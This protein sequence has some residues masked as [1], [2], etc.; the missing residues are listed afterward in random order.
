MDNTSLLPEDDF[1]K[2]K[3]EDVAIPSSNQGSETATAPVTPPVPDAM[4]EKY[5][6]GDQMLRRTEVE[7]KSF[8]LKNPDG[9]ET[10]E[11]PPIW[12]EMESTPDP[13][14]RSY[15]GPSQFKNIPS[16]DDVQTLRKNQSDPQ[17]IQEFNAV[18]GENASAS[19]LN[20]APKKDIDTLLKNKDDPAA[21]SEFDAVYG[22]GMANWYAQLYDPKS[23][24]DERTEAATNIQYALRNGMSFTQNMQTTSFG[25]FMQSIPAGGKQGVREVGQS[26]IDGILWSFGPGLSEETKQSL[27]DFRNNSDLGS[28]DT[29]ILKHPVISGII[30]G[31]SQFGTGQVIANAVTPGAGAAGWANWIRTIG[32]SALADAFAFDPNDPLVGD[33]LKTLGKSAGLPDDVVNKIYSVDDLDSELEKRL[34]R[35]GEG[36]V[37]GV[38]LE[39]L[40][41]GLVKG[42][43]A[44]GL[45]KAGDKAA[46]EATANEAADLLD[47]ASKGDP[48]TVPDSEFRT[49][50]PEVSAAERMAATAKAEGKEFDP[51][52]DLPDEHFYTPDKRTEMGLS[53][54]EETPVNQIIDDAIEHP[55][56]REAKAASEGVAPPSPAT[57]KNPLH[58]LLDKIADITEEVVGKRDGVQADTIQKV[59]PHVDEFIQ[60][61]RQMNPEDITKLLSDSYPNMK[62][63]VRKLSAISPEA[64]TKIAE[65]IRKLNIA[66]ETAKGAE[67]DDIISRQLPEQ[68]AIQEKLDAFDKPL[69]T[70]ASDAL[71]A[72]KTA[73]GAVNAA[74]NRM[75]IADMRRQGMTNEQ[76]ALHI[77]AALD[78]G[79]VE[80]PKLRKLLSDR[81]AASAKGDT[82]A[83]TKLD[84]DIAK[85]TGKVIKELENETGSVLSRVLKAAVE[86][87]LNA[88]LGG[89]KTILIN[90]PVGM[91]IGLTVRHAS[92]FV[93]V[94][95]R[96][97]LSD[98]M[99][100]AAAKN[101]AV[102][103]AY[104]GYLNAIKET[105]S[106]AASN[107]WHERSS[108]QGTEIYLQG[109]NR[110]ISAKALGIDNKL[111]GYLADKSGRVIRYATLLT[112][113]ADQAFGRLNAHWEIGAEQWWKFGQ[114]VADRTNQ[115]KRILEDTKLPA[116]RRATLEKEL[117]DLTGKDPKV[118]IGNKPMSFH[119]YLTDRLEKAFD[120]NGVL[121]DD[122]IIKQN[123]A[124]TFKNS[125]WGDRFFNHDATKLIVQP[126]HRTP[127]NEYK[128]AFEMIP[129]FGSISKQFKQDISGM[130]GARAQAIASGK[131][132]I[133]G[134][135]FMGFGLYATT[136]NMTGAGPL[137]PNE[138]KSLM[139]NGWPGPN[140][141]R[142]GDTWYDYSNWGAIGKVMM[143]SANLVEG[144]SRMGNRIMQDPKFV[145]HVYSTAE[146]VQ[147][148]AMTTAAIPLNIAQSALQSTYMQ[149]FKQLVDLMEIFKAENGMDALSKFGTNQTT[150][151]IPALVK[152]LN[153]YLDPRAVR[154]LSIADSLNSAFFNKDAV[155]KQ[156]DS[157]GQVIVSET[158]M[159]GFIGFFDGIQTKDM[160]NDN[161]V[162]QSL[163]N[164]TKLTGQSFTLDTKYNDGT[165]QVE[166]AKVNSAVGKGKVSDRVAEIYSTMK[167]G[168]LTVSEALYKALRNRSNNNV[169]GSERVKGPLVDEL[170]SIMAVYRDSAIQTAVQNELKAYRNMKPSDLRK[171]VDDS[172]AAKKFSL[173]PAHQQT[174]PNIL[175]AT[176]YNQ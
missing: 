113:F 60:I 149:G 116:N 130:N 157:L 150:G 8:I 126:F 63:A 133:G 41:R 4:V 125:T 12:W 84:K 163:Q 5:S 66:S 15:K 35:A 51:L 14:D 131:R 70:M 7:N 27:L 162:R 161:Y 75:R 166:L 100:L 65:E 156:Y 142:I 141:I 16:E 55:A 152:D 28:Q 32:T 109:N 11:K 23:G 19:Y 90:N 107:V 138:R 167:I 106:E 85:Q 160:T 56:V 101:T 48:L 155:A 39:G 46:G 173:D 26:V 47:E 17:A 172:N 136:G 50:S 25:E 18:Y 140:K 143:V 118:R 169:V 171:M 74:A 43:K 67:L 123:D 91:G 64:K 146:A 88:M 132:I 151:F 128:F 93:N 2:K 176:I 92:E 158:P 110:S 122:E 154:V 68:L 147:L 159:R 103:Q 117:A 33:M 30:E 120:E 112:D 170:K 127:F 83:V 58:S 1:R 42:M 10:V 69:A 45:I 89:L 76:I 119:E 37:I 134:T 105:F 86:W 96:M 24:Y 81:A 135:I 145:Q 59:R 175:G 98:A 44:A 71:A 139:Q 174:V 79:K 148:L 137:D 153:N 22:R 73:D 3:E 144:I 78:A 129:G 97:G 36:G 111:L 54:A 124:A 21:R 62:Q 6:V 38:A 108:L 61:L 49:Q 95:R 34:A 102:Y 72:R 121:I 57:T 20:F 77:R 168:G 80:A 31:I 114:L 82:K 29:R 13:V 104:G 94:L 87:K 9:T 40:I 165:E 52:T 99:G 53:P 115:I 164:I